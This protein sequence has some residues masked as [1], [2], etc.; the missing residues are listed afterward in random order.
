MASASTDGGRE[1]VVND[2]KEG[3]G[4]TKAAVGKVVSAWNYVVLKKQILELW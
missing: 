2:V 4:A 1:G 3:S